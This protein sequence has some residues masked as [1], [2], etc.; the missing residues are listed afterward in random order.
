MLRRFALLALI[1]A[2]AAPSLA[3]TP[4][5]QVKRGA[6]TLE[7]VP[8]TPGPVRDRLRQYTNTRSAGFFDFLPAGGVLIGTRFTNT[9]QLHAVAMP[10]GDRRQLTFFDDRITGAAAQ[11]GK[12]GYI[13]FE[14]DSGGDENFQG[15]LLDP[16]GGRYQQ[17]TEPGTRNEG[18][19]FSRDGAR[20]AWAQAKDNGDYDILMCESGK[21]YTR[22]VIHKGKGA[23]SVEDWSPT[24]DRL[25]LS[26][27]I[28]IAESKL[29]VL[30][31]GG[32]LKQLT[33]DLKVSYRSAEF[34]PDGKSVLTISDEGSEFARL[35]RIDLATDKRAV[36]SPETRWD[37]EEFDLSPDGRTLA[38]AV[39]ADG[40]S[41]LKLLDLKTGKA[42][43]TPK[44]PPGVIGAMGWDETGARL[45]LSINSATA[46]TDVYVLTTKSKSLARW[47]QSETGGLDPDDFIEPKLERFRT[48]DSGAGGPKEISA[49]VY[50]PKTPGPH[51][52]II[53][54]HGGPESQSRPTFSSNHQYWARELGMAVI[55]PNVRGST[56]YGKTFVSLDNGLKRADSVKD[57]GAVLDWMAG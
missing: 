6:L 7:N 33:P 38:Y 31:H 40:A 5:V 14:Q 35:T 46:P 9:V 25:L 39:N 44:L 34:T 45:G 30:T 56:G 19:L 3:Q 43:A 52:A 47:T 8:D 11:P 16:K 10:M 29:F 28:S 57:I 26:Q 4:P 18:P 27:Y 32:G 41:E 17:F 50:E 37:V 13:L 24:G 22:A 15:F 42:V 55:V 36:L 1:L 21:P 2:L 12:S 49:W 53:D 20:I 23:L 48:F 51:P 54:I